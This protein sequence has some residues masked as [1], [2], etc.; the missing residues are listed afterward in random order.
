[1]LELEAIEFPGPRLGCY[2]TVQSSFIGVPNKLLRVSSSVRS[3]F[4]MPAFNMI[5]S[6]LSN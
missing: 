6:T 4:L 2:L 1:M 5:S 3:I